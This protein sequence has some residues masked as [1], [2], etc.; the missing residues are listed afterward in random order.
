MQCV[1]ADTEVINLKADST[2][3]ATSTISSTDWFKLD[4]DDTLW[5]SSEGRWV[6]NPCGKYCGRMNSCELTCID[7]MW[8][9]G[10]CSNCERYFRKTI[11]LPDEIMSATLVVT[12][13]KY[14]WLYVNG[15]Y[16]G[17]D[18]RKI[19]YTNTETYDITKYILPGKNVIAIKAQSEDDTEGVAL[20]G[21]IKYKTYDTLVN[22]MQLQ[23]DG[24]E[25]QVNTLNNDKSRLQEQADSLQKENTELK[26]TKDQLTSENSNLKI[27]NLELKTANADLQTSLSSAKSSL[28]THR[29]LNMVL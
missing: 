18:T 1:S 19:G 28:N 9:G 21:E 8:Y 5:E 12:A 2:W 6:N 29:T 4:F 22:Q 7:W 17:S 20:V 15:N 23:I 14:Y 13:D 26:A 11:N 10:S 27:E 24:L 16:V 3:K 25:S